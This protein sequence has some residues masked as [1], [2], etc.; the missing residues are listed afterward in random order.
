MEVSSRLL[1]LLN[2]EPGEGRLVA[3]MLVQSFFIGSAR[4]FTRTSAYALFLAEFDANALPY[5]YIG[6]GV[7]VT[8]LSLSYLKRA[9]WAR[10]NSQYA[11]F[12]RGEQPALTSSTSSSRFS[13]S[14]RARRSFSS[15]TCAVR[16]I[17]RIWSASWITLG[18]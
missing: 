15:L 6:I 1:T 17:R 14:R 7:F 16:S 8:L 2:I 3:L 12:S 4:I 10:E 18:C 9:G 11:A 5:I 13:G